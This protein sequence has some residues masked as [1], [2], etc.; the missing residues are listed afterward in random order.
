LHIRQFATKFSATFNQIYNI[1]LVIVPSTLTTDG[2]KEGTNSVMARKRVQT[3]FLS[4]PWD[5]SMESFQAIA[6]ADAVD[7]RENLIATGR[8]LRK[9]LSGCDVIVAMAGWNS[10]SLSKTLLYV[11]SFV[12]SNV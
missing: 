5:A 12:V 3:S 4:C 10:V 9:L 1:P 8:Q 2:T 11:L 7:A 6:T